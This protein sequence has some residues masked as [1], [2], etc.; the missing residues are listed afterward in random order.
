MAEGKLRRLWRKVK[1]TGLVITITF[2]MVCVG[3]LWFVGKLLLGTVIPL[4]VVGLV[5]YL[6]WTEEDEEEDVAPF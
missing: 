4:C 2:V 3:L 6:V 5:I 1:T